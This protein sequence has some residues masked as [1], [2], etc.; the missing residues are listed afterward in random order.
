[1]GLGVGGEGAGRGN[2]SSHVHTSQK[3]NPIS[4]YRTARVRQQAC[5]GVRASFVVP[6][7][8]MRKS[9]SLPRLLA[10]QVGSGASNAVWRRGTDAQGKCERPRGA[11]DAL[12]TGRASI[13]GFGGGRRRRLGT[14]DRAEIRG[15]CGKP[16]DHRRGASSLPDGGPR[17]GWMARQCCA[18]AKA[19]MPGLCGKPF[20]HRAGLCPDRPRPQVAAEAAGLRPD[21]ACPNNHDLKRRRRYRLGGEEQPRGDARAGALRSPSGPPPGRC[22]RAAALSLARRARSTGPRSRD[23]ARGDRHRCAGRQEPRRAAARAPVRRRRGTTIRRRWGTTDDLRRT[24][25]RQAEQPW[26][27][28]SA[29]IP[30]R[31]TRR[32]EVR[33][34][35]RPSRVVG[36]AWRARPAALGGRRRGGE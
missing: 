21:R 18:A 27:C 6:R 32:Q 14:A 34:G 15:Q 9:P 4:T 12:P 36:T 28:R 17:H 35:K 10:W 26:P 23:T 29:R 25:P 2:Q 5:A 30:C 16:L 8:S 33:I 7:T 31:R 22:A 19:T 20:D 13:N 11:D 1:M 24:T 3:Q